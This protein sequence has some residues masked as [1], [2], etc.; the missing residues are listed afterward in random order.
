MPRWRYIRGLPLTPTVPGLG[1]L[2][3]GCLTVHQRP[4]SQTVLDVMDEGLKAEFHGILVEGMLGFLEAASP[5]SSG[6][7]I[8][9]PPPPV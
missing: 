2:P 9:S 6:T 8:S 3:V 7:A 1:L 4:G 5:A